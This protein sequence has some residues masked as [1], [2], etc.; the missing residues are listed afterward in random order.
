MSLPVIAMA[1]Q[2][3]LSIGTTVIGYAAESKQASAE[4]RAIDDANVRA[5]RDA[6]NDYDQLTR[7]GQQERAAA[8]QKIVA[9][10]I[11]ASKAAASTAASAGEA[12][13]GGLSIASL[14]T[15]IYGQEASIRDGVNQNLEAT[16]QQLSHDRGSIAR[17]LS[18]TIATRPK[19]SKPSVAGAVVSGASGVFGAYKDNIRI[20]SKL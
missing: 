1:A 4:G 20:K 9:N 10:Q 15:D 6:I 12:N 7:V 19:P 2:A 5:R 18:N 8:T 13:I 16:G 17:D 3:A 14:L 11:D